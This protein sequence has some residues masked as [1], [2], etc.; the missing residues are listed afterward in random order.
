[1]TLSFSNYIVL[2]AGLLVNW[3]GCSVS[4]AVP[5]VVQSNWRNPRNPL[6]S[7]GLPER[8]YTLNC[9]NEYQTFG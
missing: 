5:A 4:G 1:M 8:A 2:N 6:R 7:V 3:Q 9:E